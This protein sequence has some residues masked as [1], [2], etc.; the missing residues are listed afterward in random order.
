MLSR[1]LT[2]ARLTCLT[3]YSTEAL[4]ALSDSLDVRLEPI[5]NISGFIRINIE[6]RME[7]VCVESRS[8]GR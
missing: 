2:S 3:K 4:N 5:H 7:D 8:G 6:L 1:Q